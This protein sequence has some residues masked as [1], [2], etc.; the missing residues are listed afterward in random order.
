MHNSRAGLYTSHYTRPLISTNQ[1]VCSRINSS[2]N[3]R[4]ITGEISKHEYALQHKQKINE[5]QFKLQNPIHEI[6]SLKLQIQQKVDEMMHRGIKRKA[7]LDHEVDLNLSLG[8]E[9]RNEE[10]ENEDEDEDL[11]LSLKTRASTS[12]QI[13]KKAKADN[14]NIVVGNFEKL[15]GAS[16]L[17]LTL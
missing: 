1:D 7:A 17:D 3:E 15:R 14:N 2:F 8:V 10:D 16:T 9:P 13:T 5:G 4:R 11:A 12:K 6:N